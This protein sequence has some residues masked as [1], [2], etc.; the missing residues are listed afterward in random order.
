MT[1]QATT[2]SYHAN[3]F[4]GPL[5]AAAFTVMDRYLNSLLAVRKRRVFSDLPLDVLELGPGVGANLRYLQP[6]TRLIAI[7]PNRAMHRRLRTQAERRG[8]Q[9]DLRGI[10]AARLDADDGSVAAVI[11]SLVLCSVDDPERVVAEVL[12]VLR[13]GGRFAF[14]EH[15][16]APEGMALR[17][18]QRWVRRPWAWCLEGCSCERDLKAVIQNAGFEDVDVECYR[19]RSLLLPFNSQVAGIATKGT[20]DGGSRST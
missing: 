9:L 3:W 5:N 20:G 15:V 12:R 1:I 14:I 6:G 13:P 8:I 18:I 4:R 7:E 10:D 16:A 17:R 2:G 11:S 19:L